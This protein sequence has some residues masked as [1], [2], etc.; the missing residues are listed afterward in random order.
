MLRGVNWIAVI[1]ATVVLEIVGYL[2]YGVVF[3]DAWIAAGGANHMSL[4]QGAAYGLGV[5]N[6]LIVVIGLGWLFGRLGLAG[7]P[8]CLGVALLAWFF[9]DFTTMALDFLYQGQS[10][11]L[12]GINMGLQVVSYAL[13]GAILG[14]MPARKA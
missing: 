1:V 12:V 9:F 5:I 3:K 11:V 7:L 4:S 14:L 2:W 10:A 8:A 6:T 13:A